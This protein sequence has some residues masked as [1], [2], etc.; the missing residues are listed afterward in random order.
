M[1]NGE[2]VFVI[3]QDYYNGEV[4]IA[5]DMAYYRTEDGYEF[6]EFCYS[7]FTWDEGGVSLPN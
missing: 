5:P 6:I 1:K 3:I 4:V 2:A 7:V